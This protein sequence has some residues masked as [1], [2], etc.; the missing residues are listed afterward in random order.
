VA[1]ERIAAGA[2][3]AAAWSLLA[4]AAACA[5][6]QP[7]PQLSSAPAAFETTGRLAV[8]QGQRSDIAKVRWTHRGE[9]DVW[10]IASPL[11]NEVARIESTAGGAVMNAN[12]GTVEAPSFA[13]LTQRVLGVGIDPALLG[14]WLHAKP[15]AGA[16]AGWKVSLDEV[17]D[18]GAVRIARRITAS[19]GD[20]SVR[21]VVDSYE[22]LPSS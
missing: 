4:V 17:Q 10:V 11:G 14:A 1:F 6:V 16:P 9:S 2:R 13:D 19:R 8:R 3:R 22:A 7:L 18:A 12:G 20:V 21:W 5:T 15:E